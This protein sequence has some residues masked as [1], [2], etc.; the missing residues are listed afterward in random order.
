MLAS[1]SKNGM[2]Q[3]LMFCG[4]WNKQI[5]ERVFMFALDRENR[6]EMSM[7]MFPEDHV[8]CV[9]KTMED[10]LHGNNGERVGMRQVSYEKG[11]MSDNYF[12]PRAGAHLQLPSPCHSS[13]S[14][15][16]DSLH[17]Q[18]HF[19]RSS[20][21]I[22]CQWNVDGMMGKRLHKSWYINLFPREIGRNEGGGG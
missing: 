8:L 12:A 4:N 22:F 3:A 6:A 20:Y 9:L 17:R 13:I 1:K 11:L 7:I 14:V 10:R 21:L 5:L 18:R 15:F 19:S 2:H 16:L